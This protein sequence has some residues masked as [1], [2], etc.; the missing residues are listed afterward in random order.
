MRT[1]FVGSLTLVIA[2]AFVAGCAKNEAEV[3]GTVLMDGVPLKEGD[4]IFEAA[5]GQTTPAATKIAEGKYLLKMI[6]GEKKVLITASR[7]TKIPDPVMGDAAR[8]PL[9]GEEFN[10]KTKLTA[11]IKRGKQTGVNFEVTSLP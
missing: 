3:S 11:D 7:P 10:I 8:E 5:D 6:P 9:I 4:I 1:R 2:I